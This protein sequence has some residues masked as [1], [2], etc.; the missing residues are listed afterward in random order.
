MENARV[1]KL[2]IIKKYSDLKFLKKLIEIEGKLINK[3]S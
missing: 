3:N 1:K 2:E